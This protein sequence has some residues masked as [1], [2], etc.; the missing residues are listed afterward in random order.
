MRS[1]ELLAKASELVSGQRAKDYGPKLRNHD[2]IARLW[3]IWLKNEERISTDEDFF[4]TAYD[5]A[6]MMLLVKV[7]RLM[8]TPGHADSHI[9]IAGYAAVMEEI[10]E[11]GT[12]EVEE[13]NEIIRQSISK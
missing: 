5:V 10:W 4:I 12:K 9:D 8:T 2:R 6:M 13:F 1:E 3:N 7:A 11:D